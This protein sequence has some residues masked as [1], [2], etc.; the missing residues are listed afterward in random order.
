MKLILSDIIIKY[1]SLKN[2]RGSIVNIKGIAASN[3]IAIAKAFKLIEPELTVVKSTIADVEAE[4]NLYKEALVKTTEEL[5]KIKV[6]AAQNLSEE[7]AAVFDAHINMANDPEL[8]SQTT[9]KIKAEIGWEPETMFKEGIKKTIAWYFEH[10]D[11]MENV[12]SG[13]Y[14]NY[15]NEMYQEK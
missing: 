6:K 13:D 12:T 8:L 1:I 10:E 15:Y 9:D 3:G 2:E 4:I 7:E 5:Q 14:Q 11:W